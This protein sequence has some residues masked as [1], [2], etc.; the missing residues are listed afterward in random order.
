METFCLQPLSFIRSITR[1]NGAS[2]GAGRCSGWGR[3]LCSL[4]F[5]ALGMA[6]SAGEE[7]G[8]ETAWSW[9]LS[10]TLVRALGIVQLGKVIVAGYIICITAKNF[11]PCL[12]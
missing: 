4:F 2:G 5:V 7:R 6:A 9:G 12:A 8:A 3:G 1:E 10:P 11:S